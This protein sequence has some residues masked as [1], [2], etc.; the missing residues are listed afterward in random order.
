MINQDLINA[1]IIISAPNKL[2]SKVL[3]ITSTPTLVDSNTIGCDVQH[4]STEGTAL[5]GDVCFITISG[6]P[7]STGATGT[8]G[9][10]GTAG[11]SGRDGHNS[12]M[13]Y[14]TDTN[15]TTSP[16]TNYFELNSAW[17][18]VDQTRMLINGI[19][20]SGDISGS[21]QLIGLYGL[22]NSIVKITKESDPSVLKVLRVNTVTSTNVGG[23]LTFD[24]GVTHLSTRGTP[25]VLGAA[26]YAYI[27][28]L[29]SG[30][31]SSSGT[32]GLA[33]SSGTSGQSFSITERI[34]GTTPNADGEILI[35]R[36]GQSNQAYS[37]TMLNVQN[38]NA[39]GYF[40]SSSVGNS[41]T[42]GIQKQINFLNTE[43]NSAYSFT[44]SKAQITG[45]FRGTENNTTVPSFTG[46]ASSGSYVEIFTSGGNYAKK[47][48]A[49]KVTV[50]CIGAGGGGGSGARRA[51]NA[52][53]AG[54]GGGGGGG[55]LAISTFDNSILGA[56]TSVTIG[57]VGTGGTY[58]TVDGVG[59]A[60]IAGGESSFGS[61]LRAPGGRGGGGGAITANGR[62]DGGAAHGHRSLISTGAGPGG[63]GSNN[64]IVGTLDAP[65]L[66]YQQN[67]PF[68]ASNEI[69][70]DVAPTGGGGGAGY[71]V[72]SDVTSNGGA[73]GAIQ[74]SNTFQ[75]NNGST[76]TLYGPVVNT[77][78]STG[79]T[80]PSIS[81]FNSLVKVGLGGRGASTNGATA[82]VAGGSYGGGGGGGRGGTGAAGSGGA[83]GG[84]GVVIVI[85]E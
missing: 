3:K 31:S 75:Y 25:N 58:P 33:G 56:T 4:L 66:P 79:V 1:R 44:A 23:V 6:V 54:G 12:R 38:W 72:A 61:L 13:I 40:I 35:S 42:A 81:F 43:I 68:N 26:D 32:S 11:S 48:W 69:P 29:L 36:S 14:S 9:T 27:D 47:T 51:T 46:L 52:T 22:E 64:L 19:P 77:T 45:S 15:M 34:D 49:Q 41:V 21:L 24:L 65:P 63:R 7:G 80:A 71:G 59:N 2:F 85:T 70:A 55:V 74:P 39:G 67:L 78:T 76:Y 53:A 37:T 18:N 83:N 84:P 20:I 28:I 17:S 62:A 16:D 57:T 60:G 82:P 50:I 73:G 10:A 8:S 30:R 5:D